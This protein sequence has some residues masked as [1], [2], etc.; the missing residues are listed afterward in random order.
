MLQVFD[1]NWQ[2]LF[3]GAFMETRTL[4]CTRYHGIR[5]WYLSH[6]WWNKHFSVEIPI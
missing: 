1:A 3:K 2:L 4:Y 6:V 5:K